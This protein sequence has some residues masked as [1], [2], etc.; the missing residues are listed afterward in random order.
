MDGFFADG[1]LL[2]IH[3]PDLRRLLDNWVD[4]LAEEEFVDLLPLVRRTFATFS[5]AER[6]M[7]GERVAAR[8]VATRRP[9]P[10]AYDLERAAPALATV[11]LIL[12]GRR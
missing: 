7:I 12:G 3:D 6:R 9:Q 5:P 1:A 11:E 10:P 2:L 8:D 4:E